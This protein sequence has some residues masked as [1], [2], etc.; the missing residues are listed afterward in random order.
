MRMVFVLQSCSLWGQRPSQ[1]GHALLRFSMY[2]RGH[3]VRGQALTPTGEQHFRPIIRWIQETN[4]AVV[5]F[6]VMRKHGQEFLRHARELDLLSKLTVGWVGFNDALADGLTPEEFKR[7]VTTSPFV[8]SGPEGRMP[9][10]V[11]WVRSQHGSNN[12]NWLPTP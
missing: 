2:R 11:T 12:P 9:D 10:F 1:D 4:T 5:L 8:S 3:H 6:C 7:I